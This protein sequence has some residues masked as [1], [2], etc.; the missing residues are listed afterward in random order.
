MMHKTLYAAFTVLTLAAS[1][2]ALLAETAAPAT[3]TPAAAASDVV[4]VDDVIWIAFRDGKG[5]SSSSKAVLPSG[6]RLT[7][8]ER[9]TQ[10]GYVQ[11]RR[12]SG[13]I[14]WVQQR[15][16]SDKPTA[17]LL[18]ADAQKKLEQATA[19]R[20]QL[21]SQLNELK[22]SQHSEKQGSNSLLQENQRLKKEL[23]EI[24]NISKNEVLLHHTNK[25]LNQQLDMRT[26]EM[27][28][29][30]KQNT[31]LSAR[32]YGFTIGAAIISL[33]AGLYIGATPKRREKN[34]RMLPG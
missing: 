32:L 31:G 2:A 12:D 5:E 27:V 9:D 21:Q 8:L 26:Q 19:Q 29:L 22:Q 23:D 15:Y 28:E 30:E 10:T 13:E 11:V 14:G 25:Q 4:Y 20:N 16:L 1:P 18:L 6:T 3:T 17:D 7:V 34:W 24:R 33:I